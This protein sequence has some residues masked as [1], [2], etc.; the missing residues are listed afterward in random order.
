MDSECAFP[1][2][3]ILDVNV[4]CGGDE[5]DV[6]NVRIVRV[7]SATE[8]VYYEYL[9]PACVRLAFYEDAALIRTSGVGVWPETI[10]GST[11]CADPTSESAGA[12]CC[13]SDSFCAA[14]AIHE[15]SAGVPRAFDGVDDY[16]DAAAAGEVGGAA[17]LTIS[18]WVY[19]SSS[20]SA[21]DVLLDFGSGEATNN[22]VLSLGSSLTYQV[23]RS[24]VPSAPE[25]LQ[26]GGANLPADVW[27]HVAVAT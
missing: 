4:A 13:A 27:T 12:L 18:V 10:G 5:C 15:F 7:A 23:F 6:A 2:Q 17:G 11:M 20:G 14:A 16:I 19:R 1:S 9:Q 21:S 26:M 22:V 3:I 24:A 25:S 8:T